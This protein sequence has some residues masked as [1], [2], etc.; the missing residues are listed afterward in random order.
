MIYY[1]ITERS[2]NRKTGPMP[3]LT[4]SSETCP[5]SCPFKGKGCYG[6]G[7]PLRL[8]WEKVTKGVDKR[9][10][11]FDQLIDRI[12]DIACKAARRNV[13]RA[14]LWQ[15]GDMPGRNEQIFDGQVRRLVKAMKHFE[16]PFGYTH[17]P[18]KRNKKIIKY[19]NDN[20][21]TINLS[22]NNL[23]HADHLAS[24]NIG[25]VSVT[26]PSD[27]DSLRIF[28]PKG[29]RVVVCPAVISNTTCNSCGGVKGPLCWRVDREYII[30]FPAHGVRMRNA[31]EVAR[32]KK[33][34]Y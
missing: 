33:D 18:P 13:H 22:A 15:V 24:L 7:G 32:G 30:G 5:Q 8:H 3:V 26:L 14:R 28:T 20:G 2:T 21:V 4:S 6:D 31:S 27:L 16:M 1:H 17:K 19:C 11:T 12:P 23:Y 9:A 29:R 10:L 34:K 25:P